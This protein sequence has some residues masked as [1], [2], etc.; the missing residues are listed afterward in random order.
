[1]SAVAQHFL[2][3]LLLRSLCKNSVE[4]LPTLLNFIQS[5]MKSHF[6]IIAV[7]AKAVATQLQLCAETTG[8]IA[9]MDKEVDS[10][11]AIIHELSQDSL[12]RR[13]YL[14]IILQVLILL[15]SHPTNITRFASHSIVAE[16]Q[17]LMETANEAEDK[18]AI[19]LW[20]IASG[21]E[22]DSENICE[23]ID[24]PIPGWL[25]CKTSLAYLLGLIYALIFIQEL[26]F[27][28]LKLICPSK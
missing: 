14:N 8:D 13:Y 23:A 7:M 24:S 6:V 4:V 16:L 11:A 28:K 10:I 5:L 1:M 27:L 3:T 19:V 21:G 2:L 15:C 9:L 17:T 20:K 22:T 18:I 12:K 25:T 26:R